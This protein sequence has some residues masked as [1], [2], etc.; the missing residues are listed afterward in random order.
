MSIFS[1]LISYKSN[2]LSLLLALIPMSFIAGN[3]IININIL[4]LI[5]SSIFFFHKKVFK[6]KFFILDKLILLYFSIILASALINDHYF[7]SIDPSDELQRGIL[8][9]TFKS[10]LFLKYL[11]LYLVVRFLVENRIVNLKFF[12]I[13]CLFSTAFVS[14]DIFY[15]LLLLCLDNDMVVV[16]YC[17]EYSLLKR[18]VVMLLNPRSHL[19]S[20][21][22]FS[23]KHPSTYVK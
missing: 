1:N 16:L 9:T 11:L 8:Y 22:N 10:V 17:F 19:I 14:I 7:Y 23:K 21:L 20:P 18:L 3:M 6:L 15:Q 4:F 13:T 5:L 2:Y 12:F